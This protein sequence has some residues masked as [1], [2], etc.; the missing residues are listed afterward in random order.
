MLYPY[1]S[2][3]RIE[4]DFE[5][6]DKKTSSVT[7]PVVKTIKRL[8][9]SSDYFIELDIEMPKSIQR[10]LQQSV[11]SVGDDVNDDS[12][13]PTSDNLSQSVYKESRKHVVISIPTRKPAST[14]LR[15]SRVRSAI[16]H[17]KVYGLPSRSLYKN[18]F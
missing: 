1:R 8:D 4:R 11:V 14:T 16:L 6:L 5:I 10:A 12:H 2:P 13:S 17:Q 7:E 9:R 3:D 18:R 15:R